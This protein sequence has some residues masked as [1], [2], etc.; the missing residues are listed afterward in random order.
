MKKKINNSYLLLLS[1]LLLIIT[2]FS[3]KEVYIAPKL[4]VNLS[5]IIYPITFLISA[6]IYHKYKMKEAKSSIL[7]SI[8]IVLL[9]YLVASLLCSFNST[10]DTKLASDTLRTVFTP[11]YFEIYNLIIYYPNL[12]S[13]LSLLGIYYLSHYIFLIVYEASSEYIN[14]IVAFLISLLIA[15]IID[16]MLY[17]PVVNSIVLF[18][19][20]M[21]LITF[22]EKL[23]ANFIVVVVSTVILTFIYPK[24]IKKN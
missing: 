7:S 23:T 18:K 16:Q 15:F 2:I 20:D 11:N 10:L 8:L 14:F 5:L 6:I 1:F 22:I 19:G 13:L 24:C 3:G 21:S 17:L 12:L 9:F 4:I